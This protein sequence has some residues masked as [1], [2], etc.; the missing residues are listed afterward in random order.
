MGVG[1]TRNH[2]KMGIPP[3]MDPREFSHPGL[4]CSASGSRHKD[5]RARTCTLKTTGG[6]C[7]ERLLL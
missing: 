5:K 7:Y 3:P 1:T 6:I 4:K 2:T